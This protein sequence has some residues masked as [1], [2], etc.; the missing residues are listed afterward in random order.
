[1]KL[2]EDKLRSIIREEVSRLDET[3]LRQISNKYA[4]IAD[5]AFNQAE[6]RPEVARDH[7]QA[8]VNVAQSIALDME[9]S[10]KVPKKLLQELEDALIRAQV[11]IEQ[12]LDQMQ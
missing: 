1:M 11:S 6:E 7:I 3:R 4:K 10:G 8:M 12:M 5:E 2:A 9:R